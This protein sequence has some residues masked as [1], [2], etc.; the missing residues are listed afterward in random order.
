MSSVKKPAKRSSRK[1]VW[2][3]SRVSESGGSGGWGIATV[4]NNGR[5]RRFPSLYIVCSLKKIFCFLISIASGAS[6]KS[7]LILFG[8]ADQRPLSLIFLRAPLSL[9]LSSVR[10]PASTRILQAA[11]RSELRK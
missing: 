10:Q 6:E 8:V 2:T 7:Q 1:R 9:R 11:R 4:T 3:V 5:R